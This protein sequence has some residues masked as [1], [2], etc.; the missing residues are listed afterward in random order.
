M[1]PHSRTSCA[2]NCKPDFYQVILAA[3]HV[4]GHLMNFIAGS[5]VTAIHLWLARLA[6]APCVFF[7]FI[8]L[9]TRRKC[10]LHESHLGWQTISCCVAFSLVCVS[11]GPN[12]P[13]CCSFL[14]AMSSFGFIRLADCVHFHWQEFWIISSRFCG[15]VV[16]P[17]T[18]YF[19]RCRVLLRKSLCRLSS[20]FGD[21]ESL[22]C[23]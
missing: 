12:E 3:H 10:F 8:I 13:R 11:M 14:F 21:C 1:P 23:G 9:L 19:S 7:L 4:L 17:C 22:G 5:S 15:S 20:F 2:A 6:L 16:F 18:V